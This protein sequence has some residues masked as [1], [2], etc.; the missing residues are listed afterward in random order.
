M[1]RPSSQKR[2]KEIADANDISLAT[3]NEIIMSQFEFLR[4]LVRTINPNID[5]YPVMQ[6]THL[7]K[8]IVTDKRKWALKNKKKKNDVL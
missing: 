3:A 8:F 2:L 5:Y 1:H 4:S 6:F 7:G